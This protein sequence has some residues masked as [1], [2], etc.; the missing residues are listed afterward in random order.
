[1]NSG[2]DN[3]GRNQFPKTIALIEAGI[4]QNLHHGFQLYVSRHGKTVADL[5][6]GES[7][8][9]V[10]MTPDTLTL[11]LSSGKPVTSV[12]I[13][14]LREQGK[15]ELDNPVCQFIPEFSGRG[16]EDITLKHLLTHT[17]SLKMIAHGWPQIE[18]QEVLRR[19]IAS[20]LVAD[21]PLG[22]RAAYQP[23]T[24][25]FLLGEIIQRLTGFAFGDY[26][27]EHIFEPCGMRDTWN[28]IPVDRFEQY[29]TRISMMYQRDKNELKPLDWHEA[30]R[31]QSSSPGSNCRGPARELGHFYEMLLRG[32]VGEWGEPVLQPESLEL[33]T[34][35]Y[36]E[37]LFN[38]TFQ[39]TIDMGLGVILD[40]NKY[41]AEKVPYGFG[42]Y[43]SEQ[44]FGHGG[45]QSSI[46]FV[47]PVNELVVVAIANGMAGEPKH[48]RRAREINNSLYEE[49]GLS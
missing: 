1:M 17:S 27:R 18:W 6:I 37:G 26:V 33:L 12:A 29:G 4:E 40:S 49:L 45:A 5:G 13:L 11:W 15:L 35:K 28:G 9:G 22:E 2:N 8:P 23:A 10:P 25:W 20:E 24:S 3:M 30:K 36:T 46:G 16:K 31:C 32:G 39:F 21:W 14:Q 7:R 48:N 43:C 38:E 41:G 42:R 19:I 34:K 44:T 47:D